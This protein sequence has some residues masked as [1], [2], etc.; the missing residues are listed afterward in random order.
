MEHASDEALS[1]AIC[2]MQT[3]KKPRFV[4]EGQ[5]PNLVSSSPILKDAARKQHF[6]EVRDACMFSAALF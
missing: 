1:D 4:D 5:E 2:F 3:A 6:I